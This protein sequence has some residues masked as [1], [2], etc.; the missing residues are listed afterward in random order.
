MGHTKN[1]AAA[2]TLSC[3][4]LTASSVAHADYSYTFMI[5]PLSGN[6]TAETG[7]FFTGTLINPMTSTNINSGTFSYNVSG[8][9]YNGGLAGF[10]GYYG[11]SVS[12]TSINVFSS[13][14]YITTSFRSASPIT[15]GKNGSFTAQVFASETVSAPNSPRFEGAGTGLFEAFLSSAPSGGGGGSGGAPTP[16]VNAGLGVLLAGASFAF[17]RRKR[18]TR[19]ELTAA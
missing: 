19:H 15:Y 3:L 16:E 18:G 5:T 12:P 8:T 6:L 9:T 2:I 1:F 11:S 13:V 4:A 7:T 17:L 14:S 10:N